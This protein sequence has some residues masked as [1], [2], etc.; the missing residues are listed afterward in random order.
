MFLILG[1]TGDK[2][3]LGVQIRAS[4]SGV[5]LR[6]SKERK[7]PG[8]KKRWQKRKSHATETFTPACAYTCILRYYYSLLLQVRAVWCKRPA[9]EEITLG[10]ELR[11]QPGPRSAQV[12]LDIRGQGSSCTQNTPSGVCADKTGTGAPQNEMATRMR[13]MNELRRS[14]ILLFPFLNASLLFFFFLFSR[15]LLLARSDFTSHSAMLSIHLVVCLSMAGP[16]LNW[17]PPTPLP[18]QYS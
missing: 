1:T 10:S 17:P 5:V 9:A 12:A 13:W 6:P 3:Q 7:L 16:V 4:V 15:T 11:D 18:T 8:K 2:F 14:K